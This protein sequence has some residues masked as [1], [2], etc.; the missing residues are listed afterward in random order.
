MISRLGSVPLNQGGG[1]EAYRDAKAAL[2]TLARSLPQGRHSQA[3]WGVTLMHPGW[4]R[5][6]L[7]GR[8]ATLDV[9]TSARGMVEVLE[10]RLGRRGC[11]FVDYKGEAVAR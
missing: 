2:N 4:A 1:W 6:D 3:P 11:V 10:G 9:A 7:G 5:T 8:R